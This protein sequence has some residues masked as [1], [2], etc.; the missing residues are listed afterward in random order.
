MTVA[1]AKPVLD[2]IRRLAAGR[3]TLPSD[4]DLL[5]RSLDRGRGSAS[6]ALVEGQGA[7]VFGV[8]RAVLPPRHDAEDAFQGAFLVLARK[9]DSIRRPDGLAGWLHGVACRVAH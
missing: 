6:R 5:Q 4:R 7:R 9:A 8:C 3:G 1:N 2:H